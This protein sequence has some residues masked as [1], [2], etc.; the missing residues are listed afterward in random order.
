MESKFTGS[1]FGLFGI[2]ILTGLITIITLGICLPFAIC[3][4]EKWIATH[5]YINGKQLTFNGKASQLIGRYIVWLLLSIIT[6]GIY[7]IFLT[8]KTKK[9]VVKHTHFA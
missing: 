2:N 7:S 9:W 3:K 8:I 6:A 5:T 4:K 1:T